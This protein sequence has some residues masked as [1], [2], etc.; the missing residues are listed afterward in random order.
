VALAPLFFAFIAAVVFVGKMNVG[1]AGVE[2]AAR[3]AA[4]TISLSRTPEIARDEAEATARKIVH[5]GK[6]M[7]T[8]MK[9]DAQITGQEVTVTVSC[10]VDLSEAS[11]IGVPGTKTVKATATEIIDV[12]RE[13]G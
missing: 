12:Y 8:T 11:L 2:A 4:R 6:A 7:C 1:S 9:F 5:E 3:T 10:D 13:R